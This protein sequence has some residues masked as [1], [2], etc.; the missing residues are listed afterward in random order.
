MDEKRKP[1]AKGLRRTGRRVLL[2]AFAASLVAT[3][4]FAAAGDLDTTFSKDGK[5]TVRLGTSS[6]AD[7]VKVQDNGKIL[8]AGWSGNFTAVARYTSNGNLDENYGQGGKALLEHPGQAYS[9]AEEM[10]LDDQ[11]RALLVGGVQNDTADNDDWQVVRLDTDGDPDD[12]FGGDGFVQLDFLGEH[13]FAYDVAQAPGDKVV[14]VGEAYNPATSSFEVAVAR[15][16][17]DGDPDPTFGG[18]D[19]KEIYTFDGAVP[20][21]FV[22]SL[23]VRDNGKIILGIRR[24]TSAADFVIAQVNEDG[25]VDE[26]FGNDGVRFVDFKGQRDSTRALAWQGN[27]IIMGGRASTSAGNAVWGLVRFT[28]NGNLDQTFGRNGRVMTNGYTDDN[29]D[30]HDIA[31]QGDDKIVAVGSF[32]GGGDFI[33]ARYK[34]GGSLDPTFSGDGIRPI[35]FPLGAAARGV[36]IH[37][38]RIVVGGALNGGVTP[39]NVFATAVLRRN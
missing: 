14:A 12:T 6:W 5:S 10:S 23:L 28:S 15:F 19:G 20:E 3:S 25:N 1:G 38:N 34:P 39:G 24:A 17:S 30:L 29:D 16:E 8:L 7:D 21:G 11:G 27:K 33:V 37:E 31:V 18:G 13:D 4:A 2:A 22:W 35:S 32:V 26:E 36:D 9:W